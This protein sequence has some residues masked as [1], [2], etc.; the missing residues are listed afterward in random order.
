MLKSIVCFLMLAGA[1]QSEAFKKEMI[2]LQEAVDTVVSN[3]GARIMGMSDRSRATYLDG[4]GIVVVLEVTLEQPSHP[5]GSSKSPA[6]VQATVSQRQKAIKEKISELLKQR[7]G[8]TE[9]VGATE[10]IAVIVHF[11]NVTRADVPD[12]PIQLVFR[13][14][15]DTPT[16]VK[17]TEFK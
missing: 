10:S 9:S 15:K 11:L 1:P 4:Y 13:V 2:P 14:R 3:T 12:L 17:I 6:E 8:K 5:F 16:E 7:V